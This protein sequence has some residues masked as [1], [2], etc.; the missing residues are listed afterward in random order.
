[1]LISELGYDIKEQTVSEFLV[2]ILMLF[3]FALCVL[4]EILNQIRT[5]VYEANGILN[6]SCV[7][8]R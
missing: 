1:M 5:L 7:C 4:A 3:D 8:L 6:T 2:K